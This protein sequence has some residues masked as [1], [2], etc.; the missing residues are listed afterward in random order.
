MGGALDVLHMGY[1]TITLLWQL[2]SH[3][4]IY[5]RFG[6]LGLDFLWKILAKTTPIIYFFS[7]HT[8]HSTLLLLLLL[9]LLFFFF[10]ILYKD[11]TQ[12]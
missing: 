1:G 8:L 11:K 7:I 5:L 12:L 3:F 2:F 4:G 6:V 9:L 10:H